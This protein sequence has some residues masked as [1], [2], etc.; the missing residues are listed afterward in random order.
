MSTDRSSTTAPLCHI[1]IGRQLE[2]VVCKKI[3]TLVLGYPM[4]KSIGLVEMTRTILAV[5]ERNFHAD[6]SF[7]DDDIGTTMSDTDPNPSAE[8]PPTRKRR[9]CGYCGYEG[10]DRRNCQY[11]PRARVE[12]T[13]NSD[14]V[15]PTPPQI[16]EETPPTAP[17]RQQNI[18]EVDMGHCIYVIF[19]LE[20]TGFSK[21]RHHIIEIAGKVLAPDATPVDNGSFQSLVRPPTRIPP[22]VIEL[23][24]ITDE[25]VA[26]ARSFS[27]V[28]TDFINFIK[29][30]TTTFQLENRISV[31]RII[32]VAHNGKRFDIPFLL[33]SM[34]RHNIPNICSL[35]DR[36]GI[37]IDTLEL[38]K[39]GIRSVASR[40]VP[41]S[42]SLGNLYQHITGQNLDNSHRAMSDVEATCSI[43][44]YA[45]FWNIRKQCLF[46]FASSQTLQANSL[47]YDSD[48][49]SGSASIG[50]EEQVVQEQIH[51]NQDEELSTSS[52]E[53]LGDT[54]E[55]DT[56]FQPPSPTPSEIFAEGFTRQSTKIR[57]G[58]Q[59]S[60]NSVNSPAKAWKAVFTNFILDKIVAYTNEYGDA[61]ADRWTAVTR[62]DLIDFIS[63]LFLAAVVKR[64]DKPGNWFSNDPIFEFPLAKK[65]TSGRK[66]STMLRYLHCCSLQ[67]QPTGEDYDPTYKVAEVKDYLEKRFERLFLPLQQLSLD[68]TLI[69]SFGRVKF[70]VRIVTKAARYGI[71]VYVLADAATSFVL[72]VLFYTGK[73]TYYDSVDDSLKKTVQVV[74]SLCQP[75]SNTH[76]T[77]Y[78]DRFY[79]SVELLK[80]LKKMKLYITGTVM[81]NRLPAD[82]RIA[83]TSQT[84]KAMKRGDFKSHQLKFKDESGNFSFAGLV[85]WRD[86]D[87][88]YCLTNDSDTNNSDHCHRRSKDGII[89]IARPTVI[90]KYNKFMGGVDVADMR[91]LHCNSTIM[92]QNRWWLKLFFY[93]LDVGTSNALVM[94]NESVGEDLRMNIVEF[95]AK[96]IET[97]V[98]IKFGVGR[99]IGHQEIVHV[100]RR[101]NSRNNCAYCALFSLYRRT[102]FHC[103][104]CEVPLCSLGSGHVDKD[105]FTICHES[106]K[107]REMVIRKFE[108]MKKK[109]N[110]RYLPESK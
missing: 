2:H 62:N 90:S 46:E 6:V 21:D 76:R 105:C 11:V 7:C 71:K 55:R 22:V 43:M 44:Q 5:V 85:C 98:G 59:C 30:T 68:E 75:Y 80:E 93:L 87:I 49:D 61:M 41:A 89:E 60:K 42:Y 96:L 34:E 31:E 36:F 70:K 48:S 19:D 69:R 39:K 100:P 107:T 20:T 102:R 92:G 104:G 35:D 17:P 1:R 82:L 26:R 84:F 78:V 24:G 3:V 18:T 13:S 25:M 38:S 83:K 33:T 72:R 37:L 91:R 32:L 12:N 52:D 16:V 15:E 81:K 23:T 64:K 27:E 101:S 106:E 73:R 94:Y 45:P 57:T 66:F 79:T 50:G 58:L 103:A 54:W 67:N 9:K 65:I 74:K 108:A 95:K 86:R 88:V 8:P 56:E 53:A 47:E 110:K 14:P 99:P 63:I 10:H 77:V 97:F 51:D 29:Q 4:P 40:S 109:T 28:V